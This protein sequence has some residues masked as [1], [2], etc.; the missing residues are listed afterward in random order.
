M[1]MKME[2]TRQKFLIVNPNSSESV[3]ENLQQLLPTPPS[4][5]L[6]FYTGP[7]EAPPEIDG[8]ET[9]KK[10]TE[11][12]LPDLLKNYVDHYDGYLICCYSDHPLIYELRNHTEKP[13]LGIFQASVIYAMSKSPSKFGILTSTSSWE[14]ILDTAVADFFGSVKIPLFTGTVASNINVL[15]LGDPKYF[16]KLVEKAQIC[17]EAGSKTVLLGCA[18]LSGL[19]GKLEAEFQG[20]R[21]IDSVKIGSELL[22]SLVRFDTN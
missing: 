17:V 14:S 9:S 7:P 5:E 16:K 21:F 18:G 2:P 22:N 1:N 4:T 15:K 6:T 8:P 10:S 3:T 19:E 12:C 11:A 20:V 13:V